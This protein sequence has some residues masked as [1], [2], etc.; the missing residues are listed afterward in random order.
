LAILRTWCVAPESVFLRADNA[1]VSALCA[2]DVVA[3][4]RWSENTLE[5]LAATSYFNG[6]TSLQDKKLHKVGYLT[7]FFLGLMASPRDNVSMNPGFAR[8]L[9]PPYA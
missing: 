5:H 7:E 3:I 1:A 2:T 9:G 6:C 8:C 4:F